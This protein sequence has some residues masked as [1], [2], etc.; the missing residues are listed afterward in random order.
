MRETTVWDCER[1]CGQT[2]G[3]GPR[4][5][6]EKQRPTDHTLP[7]Q[8]NENQTTSALPSC[9]SV[10]VQLRSWGRFGSLPNESA[11]HLTKDKTD[12]RPLIML[13]AY[14]TVEFWNAG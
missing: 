1:L 6:K 5:G 11:P 7:I 13:Y 9:I 2:S 8:A 12:M 14:H 4:A 3:R 10:W